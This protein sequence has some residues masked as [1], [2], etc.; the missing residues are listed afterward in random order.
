MRV[1]HC[2]A[3]PAVLAILCI[4]AS[5]NAADW[6]QFMR[7]AQHTGDAGL[8]RLSIHRRE[9]DAPAGSRDLRRRCERV[10]LTEATLK[11][12]ACALRRQEARRG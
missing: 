1:T 11:D 8:G 2:P 3:L 6:P 5:A 10:L 4:A 12:L 7:D 9:V